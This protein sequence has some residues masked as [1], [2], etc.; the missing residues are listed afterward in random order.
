MWLSYPPIEEADA[1][2]RVSIVDK[3]TETMVW[4]LDEFQVSRDTS[5]SD[6]AKELRRD[7]ETLS[8]LEFRRKWHITS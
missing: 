8:L 7:L 2:N 6:V 3:Q 5:L 4:S 1:R